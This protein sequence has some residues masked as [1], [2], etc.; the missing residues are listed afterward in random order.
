MRLLTLRFTG[1]DHPYALTR[2][3]LLV[4][5]TPRRWCRVDLSVLGERLPTSCAEND[6][7]TSSNLVT[8]RLVG[9]DRVALHLSSKFVR[10]HIVGCDS[11]S[12]ASESWWEVRGA[13]L[14]PLLDITTWESSVSRCSV[15]GQLTTREVV[16]SRTFPRVATVKTTRSTTCSER[17]SADSN[18]SENNS[19]CVDGESVTQDAWHWTGFGFAPSEMVAP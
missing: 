12:G 9:P 14:E 4:T 18:D 2:W 8:E 5:E 16:W 6:E 10:C 1:P 11:G 15:G 17:S 7:F 19:A 13:V 3:S